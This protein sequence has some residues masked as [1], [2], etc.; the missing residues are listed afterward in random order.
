MSG[1]DGLDDRGRGIGRVARLRAMDGV[2]FLAALN[3][4]IGSRSPSRTGSVIGRRISAE[5]SRFDD[6]DRDAQWRKLAARRAMHRSALRAPPWRPHSSRSRPWTCAP[7]DETFHD[8]FAAT[9]PHAG[10][11]GLD[12]RDGPEDVGVEQLSGVAVVAFLDGGAVAVARVIH[13]DVGPANRSIAFC[14]A[15]LIWSASV[16][17][18]STVSTLRRG[19]A[20]SCR[21]ETLR[22]VATTTPT[23]RLRLSTRR[24]PPRRAYS[25]TC[26]VTRPFVDRESMTHRSNGP[27]TFTLVAVV[28]AV[29]P[30]GSFVS[31]WL[32]VSSVT[33]FCA[34][35]RTGDGEPL[36][37]HRILDRVALL[38][39]GQRHLLLLHAL[40]SLPSQAVG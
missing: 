27:V 5:G 15:R 29:T 28:H 37:R 20:R 38:N 18:S 3:C 36:T 34:V 25:L 17:S 4:G 40:S 32:S 13:Q 21:E 22:A 16:T 1:F 7:I 26:R 2:V 30:R 19:S 10:E 31:P 11:D 9:A 8:C 6:G 24:R 12:H 39:F 23:F 33:L 14:T 35:R